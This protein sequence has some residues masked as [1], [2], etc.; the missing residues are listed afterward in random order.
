[1]VYFYEYMALCL[2]ESHLIVH[3]PYYKYTKPINHKSGEGFSSSINTL[4]IFQV[5]FLFESQY[6][7]SIT[8]LITGV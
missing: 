4:D 3:L 5:C 8:I 6:Y 1:M 2:S 7:L